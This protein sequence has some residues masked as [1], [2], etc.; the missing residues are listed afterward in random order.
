MESLQALQGKCK[1]AHRLKTQSQHLLSTCFE[2]GNV[3]GPL[4]PFYRQ[5]N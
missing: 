4:A 1:V 3:L 5:A 2:P